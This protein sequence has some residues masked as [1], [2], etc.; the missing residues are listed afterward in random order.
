MGYALDAAQLG[1]RARLSACTSDWENAHV[2]AVNRAYALDLRLH[3]AWDVSAFTFEV[4]LGG[5]LT[6][7]TQDFEAR[8]RAPGRR[9]LAP[10]LALGASVLWELGW[11]ALYLSGDLSAETHFIRWQRDALSPVDWTAQLALRAALG[12]GRH[13]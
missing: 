7:L 2:R 8:G 1:A 10:F 12:L 9:T 3:H 11:E 4:G 13:F 6:L 5:G